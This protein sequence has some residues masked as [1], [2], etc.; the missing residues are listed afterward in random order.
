M[1]ANV[2][3]FPLESTEQQTPNGWRSVGDAVGQVLSSVALRGAFAASAYPSRRTTGG[4]WAE[5][6]AFAEP[7]E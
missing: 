3:P 5:A 7:A 6:N 1:L 2:V 4:D